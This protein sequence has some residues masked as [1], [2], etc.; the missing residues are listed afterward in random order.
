MWKDYSKSYIKHNRSSSISIIAAALISALCLSFLCGFFYNIWVGE[1]NNIIKQEGDW[2]GRITGLIVDED[3]LIIRNFANVERAEINMEM[4][5]VQEVVVD[6]YFHNM[7]TIFQDMPLITSQLGLE[8]S[9][10]E[11][12]LVL[13]S[14][15]LIHDP[16]DETPPLLMSFYI[17]ILLIMSISL[18][19][20]IHNSFAVSM[21]AR[22]HQFGIFSSIGATPKQIRTCLVQEAIVL[23][24]VP[25]IIGTFLGIAACYGVIQ[26][27]NVLGKNIPGAYATAFAYHPAVFLVTSL[28][29]ILTVLIS[30]WIP[31]RKLSK[32]T[33][34]EAIRNIGGFQLKRKKKS[35]IL[36]LLFGME[37]ELAGNALKAQKKALRTSTL[38]LTL[39]FL[40]FTIILCFFTLSGI[41]TRHT[42]FDKYQDVWDVMVTV[43]NTK[44]EDLG[45]I[46]ELKD[47]EGVQD[48]I[49]YQKA[50][51]I[52]SFTEEWQSE[53]LTALGGLGTLASIP[54]TEEG[55]YK[56]ETPIVVLDDE[57][58]VKYCETIGVEPQLDGTIILNRIW[59]SINSVFRYPEYI[60]F[61]QESQNTIVLQN[62]AQ[63]ETVELP[64]LGYTQEVPAL[65]EEYR[66]YCLVQF[67]STSLWK[68]ISTQIGSEED[69]YIR[70]LGKEGIE[71]SEAEE[72]EERISKIITNE[73]EIESENRIGEKI[74]NDYMIFGYLVILG[75]FCGL[76]ATIG[77]ANVFSN[78]LGFITQRKREF[79]QYMSVGMSPKGISKIFSIEALVIAGRPLLIT[80]PLTVAFVQFAAKASYL[81]PMEFWVKAPI[82]PI[83][84]FSL[85]I[86]AF[87]TLAYYIGGKRILGCNLNEALRND[88]VA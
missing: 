81:N 79:A 63:D 31:A 86:F 68:D 44:I 80:L 65:R 19:L 42:Y 39:S 27:M 85:A 40:S 8:E 67:I 61:V 75:G 49:V 43:K 51:A 50:S 46:Q 34:L 66:D 15:Y 77:I 23:C 36:T 60:P 84:I 83:A 14:R 12:N 71:L 32:M 4:S 58:F 16:Q 33:P 55:E 54:K 53:E 28:I 69:I 35:P 37:G 88:T 6:I 57:S 9:L 45:L 82:L 20:V 30:A 17:V 64:I 73:F 72:I 78:T 25:I 41:S 47:A 62:T 76:L 22:I 87:V 10:A 13:L 11:Y 48:C 52:S 18:I 26:A 74:T 56:V 3:L 29:S 70:I 2:Q 7:R 38:S 21:R 24:L 1:I 5:Q 59:D